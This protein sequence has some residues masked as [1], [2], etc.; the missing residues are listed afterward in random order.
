M[1]MK[2]WRF[3]CCCFFF[4]FFF[5]LFYKNLS[6]YLDDVIVPPIHHGSV[7][8]H[9]SSPRFQE[10]PPPP[11][12]HWWRK[13]P[14]MRIQRASF[15]IRVPCRKQPA[16]SRFPL[17]WAAVSPGPHAEHRPPSLALCLL[18]RRHIGC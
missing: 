14:I 12:V 18:N 8:H 13:T 1:T 17:D 7:Q 9:F 5:C 10:S 3:C 11:L 15:P 2:A 16:L 4:V 6:S